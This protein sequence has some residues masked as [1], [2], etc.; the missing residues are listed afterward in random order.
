[1]HIEPFKVEIWMD[2]WANHCE[3]NLAETCVARKTLRG[4]VPT[5]EIIATNQLAFLLHSRVQATYHLSHSA[6]TSQTKQLSY[7]Q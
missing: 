4:Q 1:M 2:E 3:Y 6:V 7:L 5:Q